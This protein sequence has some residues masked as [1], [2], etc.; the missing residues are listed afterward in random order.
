MSKRLLNNSF[1]AKQFVLLVILLCS[2]VFIRCT[3]EKIQFVTN[4]SKERLTG[5]TSILVGKWNWIYSDHE[6]GW[7]DNESW[8]EVLTPATESTKFTISFIEEGIVFFYKND[9]LIA[10]YRITFRDF[11]ANSSA[12]ETAEGSKYYIYLDSTATM[13]GCID[14]DTLMRTSFTGFI[15][16]EQEGCGFYDNFFVKE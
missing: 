2:I 9:L 4:S 15:F 16:R 5:D 11:G 10:E 8:Y 7:C 12:C 3:K 14:Y 6:Y 13:S 1:L